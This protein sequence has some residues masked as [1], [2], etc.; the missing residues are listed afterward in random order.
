M[1]NK[2]IVLYGNII[3]FLILSIVSITELKDV[4]END[5]DP[6]RRKDLETVKSVVAILATIIVLFFTIGQITT[7]LLMENWQSYYF[8][9]IGLL[10]LVYGYTAMSY[11]RVFNYLMKFVWIFIIIVGLAIVFQVYANFFKSLRGI[12][13]FITYL[14]FYI[15]CLL[16]NFLKYILNE[17]KMTTNPVL[18]LFMVELTLILSY[19]YLPGIIQQIS[20]KDGIP[21]EKSHVYL[22]TESIYPMNEIMYN[23]NNNIQ[24]T[25]MQDK[26]IRINY[27]I[28]MWLFVNDYSKNM[29]G[30]NKET[31]IFNYGE[32]N[33]KITYKNKEANINEHDKMD[34]CRIYFTDNVQTDTDQLP[35]YDLKMPSQK[36]NHIVFNYTS[37][38]VDLFING[39]LE[40]TYYFKKN[41]PTY[42]D[43]DAIITGSENGLSGSICNIRYYKKNLSQRDIINIYNP[44]MN[45]NPPVNNL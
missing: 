11:F 22:N 44:L 4:P 14:I 1:E 17:F 15:P 13:S 26:T 7:P 18:V 33:P 9:T 34:S 29:A 43:S 45:K 27:A 12:F 19:L 35:Y 36:W 5:D 8:G 21:I 39:K 10:A 6:Y 16:L 38:H 37:K 40:R 23:D 25:N 30:Y 32:G 31:V 2:D 28:S 20:M 41:I 42:K 24:I 3:L